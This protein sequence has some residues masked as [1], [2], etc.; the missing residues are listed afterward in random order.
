M[1]LISEETD[2]KNKIKADKQK[3]AFST[4]PY[5]DQFK[6]EVIADTATLSDSEVKTKSSTLSNSSHNR[7]NSNNNN[8]STSSI[9]HCSMGKT[10]EG[11]VAYMVG[12]DE[13][14][15][16]QAQDKPPN[17]DEPGLRPDKDLDEVTS[18]MKACT[19]YV[20]DST[21]GVEEDIVK[22]LEDLN[23]R[24]TKEKDEL[25]KTVLKPQES[26]ERGSEYDDD[27]ESCDDN[28]EL[29]ETEGLARLE[30]PALEC[31]PRAGS[32]STER[33]GSE[34]E[35]EV[36]DRGGPDGGVPAQFQYNHHGLDY[37]GL[38]MPASFPNYS[39][40]T[41]YNSINFN[42]ANC[43]KRTMD[44]QELVFDCEPHKYTRPQQQHLTQ[45]Q[46]HQSEMLN[47]LNNPGCS[48][49]KQ[50]VYQKQMSG[51][52][53]YTNDNNLPPA[54]ETSLN[55]NN[56][57]VSQQQHQLE[58]QNTLDML[59]FDLEP[60]I[61]LSADDV[62]Q[63]TGEATEGDDPTPYAGQNNVMQQ[64]PPVAT[65]FGVSGM[66]LNTVHPA[67]TL[68]SNLVS[69][70]Q[71]QPLF[72]GSHR[73]SHSSTGDDLGYTSDKTDNG[74]DFE[75]IDCSLLNK[76]L[77][78]DCDSK[79]LTE[80]DDPTFIPFDDVRGQADQ[81][82]PSLASVESFL[83]NSALQESG[84]NR[85]SYGSNEE[86]NGYNSEN[87]PQH[88]MERSPGGSNHGIASSPPRSNLSMVTEDSGVGSPMSEDGSIQGKSPRHISNSSPMQACPF[89][90]AGPQTQARPQVFPQPK[91][92]Q[93]Q[94]PFQHIQDALLLQAQHQNG[95][96][97]SYS[98]S[99]AG[100][101]ANVADFIISA[102][103]TSQNAFVPPY[104]GE[105]PRP[106]AV[107]PNTASVSSSQDLLLNSD[108][109]YHCDYL[110]N[111][112]QELVDALSI[113][114]KDLE[115]QIQANRAGAGLNQSSAG[116]KFAP[117]QAQAQTV[118]RNP[119]ING[120]TQVHNLPTTVPT[121][122]STPGI[123]SMAIPGKHKDAQVITQQP[124]LAPSFG[125]NS[126][127]PKVAIPPLRRPNQQVQR[128]HQQPFPHV[129]LF[130]GSNL[131]VPVLSAP[132]PTQKPRL[133][134]IAPK[135]QN[136][137][138]P[139]NPVA[140]RGVTGMSRGCTGPS[141]RLPQNCGNIQGPAAVGV[142]PRPMAAAQNF[143]PATAAPP[144]A[145]VPDSTADEGGLVESI[146]TSVL[147]KTR[148]VL[149]EWPTER[150]LEAD[151]EGDTNLHTAASKCMSTDKAKNFAPLVV[152]ILERLDR[153]N[154]LAKVNMQ[155]NLGQTALYIA[156]SINHAKLVK[157]FIDNQADV[158]LF[159]E[160]HSP[161][162]G[163]IKLAAIHCV[164]LK[165]EE[166][167]PTLKSLLTSPGIQVDLVNSDGYTALQ[168]A[169]V[170]HGKPIGPNHRVNSIP[171]VQALLQAGANP[172]FQV[173]QSGK[174][175]L[176]LALEYRHIDL[177]EAMC[178]LIE[179]AKLAAFFK[180]QDFDGSN[181]HKIAKSLKPYLDYQ[182]QQR[183]L[184]CLR[185]E[186]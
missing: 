174:T 162:R 88:E 172:D 23:L 89:S 110:D 154:L 106:Q 35:E 44:Q 177:L 148:R 24:E 72:T 107:L 59:N 163:V 43:A 129:V 58:R 93:Q 42:T 157:H 108:K 102:G 87:S 81:T 48:S 180:T 147:N 78:S 84:S 33:S 2:I 22:H 64:L 34:D 61:T 101:P 112:N 63:V 74:I 57:D 96:N 149:S 49:A 5:E 4:I 153:E 69:Q 124:P 98:V 38:Q 97:Q 47:N 82:F 91:Q 18:G 117:A 118:S 128:Q 67:N 144:Q 60:L 130:N 103:M 113:L 109:D 26:D 151:D 6:K 126:T 37:S 125:S 15:Q 28:N 142:A 184:A 80:E 123:R 27:K 20:S 185:L 66:P 138:T 160:N 85:S 116:Q 45:Q 30:E 136:M 7:F 155:N 121:T 159:A 127:A 10:T 13:G 76:I 77:E 39:N 95:N 25:Q 186:H 86:D 31:C 139:N 133:P 17:L 104:T 14:E 92:V 120:R 19:L 134:I 145:R 176:M 131:I 68:M 83:E 32:A 167:L 141:A 165:G 65:F 115:S 36:L 40:L 140:S 105:V 12:E 164:C 94:P 146:P 52:T 114:E 11:V 168:C 79:R 152:A 135:P 55:F 54:L 143:A 51:G 182:S 41:N 21:D 53:V 119:Q 173:Q 169:I 73:T 16:Q 9:P 62:K 158:N 183:L 137:A 156:A 111:K 99:K 175:A 179:P 71:Q 170:T 46:L 50:V 122:I 8:K 166:F 29:A 150:I 75:N 1:L 3:T 161:S 90:P 56:F 181:C 100:V 178:Q 132:A 70:Q 171:I